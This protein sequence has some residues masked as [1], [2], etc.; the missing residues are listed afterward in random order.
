MTVRPT[1]RC[2]SQTLNGLLE[3]PK[4]NGSSEQ[5]SGNKV[6]DQ[7][8]EHRDELYTR[9]AKLIIRDIAIEYEPNTEYDRQIHSNGSD[10]SKPTEERR[11]DQGN[12]YYL[13]QDTMH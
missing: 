1:T 13:I 4:R 6:E 12:S 7:M 5:R 10:R 3:N 9:Y 11:S 2:G 8:I